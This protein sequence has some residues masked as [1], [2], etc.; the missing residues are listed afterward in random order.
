[1]KFEITEL[2]AKLRD[3]FVMFPN[4]LTNEESLFSCA[5]GVLVSSC[6]SIS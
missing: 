3:I 4:S 6:L 2:F 1:M 5:D